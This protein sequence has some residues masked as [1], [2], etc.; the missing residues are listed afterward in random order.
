MSNDPERAS[1]AAENPQPQP[2]MLP[3]DEQTPTARITTL[4][5]Q[6]DDR[7]GEATATRKGRTLTSSP[8]VTRKTPSASVPATRELGAVRKT[9]APVPL[10]PEAERN[11]ALAT[12]NAASDSATT[13][14]PGARRYRRPA[15]VVPRRVG[16]RSIFAQFTVSTIVTAIL[17]SALA[18][19]TPLGQATGLDL[20][21]AVTSYTGAAPWLPT[22]TPTLKPTATPSFRPPAGANPGQQAV[23]NNITAV[24]G[25]YAAG[26]LAV[27]HCESGYDSNAWNSYPIMGSHASGVFQI[28]YPSTWK[29]TSYASYSPF[30]ADANIH[31]AYEIFKRDGY[32]WREW[33]CQ[34]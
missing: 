3:A 26:A 15:R 19:S 30:N 10:K 8:A 27:A 12:I 21:A 2:T 33:Q 28:L 16:P 14:I 9:Q 13:V 31:A 23:I 5:D 22:P 20:N 18:L 7:G 25:S 11:R 1:N 34:P 6:P 17:L 4:A 24:F 29:S 32:S